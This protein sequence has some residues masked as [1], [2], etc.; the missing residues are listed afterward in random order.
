MNASLWVSLGSPANPDLLAEALCV[1]LWRSAVRLGAQ[2][3]HGC[4]VHA[5]AKD[6]PFLPGNIMEESRLSIKSGLG[7]HS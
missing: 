5:L 3:L 4:A 1:A 6:I 7:A 2:Q